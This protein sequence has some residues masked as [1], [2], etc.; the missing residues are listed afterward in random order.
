MRA[1]H[2]VSASLKSNYLF[3]IA[4]STPLAHGRRVGLMATF[5]NPPGVT[6]PRPELAQLPGF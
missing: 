5:E 4:H 6:A 3:Q 1:E 2:D